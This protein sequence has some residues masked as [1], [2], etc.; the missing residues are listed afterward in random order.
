MLHQKRHLFR[1][2]ALE[3]LASPER[4]DELMLV[5][6]PRSWLPVLTLGSLVGITFFWLIYGRIP[7]I[8]EGQGVLIYPHQV[9]SLQSKSS[10]QLLTVN[11]KVGDTI[12]KGQ[13]LATINQSEL[14][15]QL[16]Q[17]RLKLTELQTQ[18]RSIS[19]LQ[20][21]TI[22]QNQQTK[23][24]QYTYLQQRI[25]ELQIQIPLLKTRENNSTK[26]QRQ[27]LEQKLKALQNLI[28]I[29]QERIDNRKYLFKEGA[30]SG[31]IPYEAELKYQ[32][33]LAQISDLKAQLKELDFKE[34]ENEKDYREKI[35][36][37]ADYQAQLK[38]L[39]SQAAIQA[40]QMLESATT[41]KKEIQDVQR[42]IARLELQ[43][44]DNSQILSPY[45]GHILELTVV[46]GQVVNPGT[47]LGVIQ[48]ENSSSKLIAVT[49]FSV[50]DGKKIQPGMTV[51][52]TPQIV[53]REQFGG[54]LGKV[55][56][57]SP[58][59]ITKEAAANEVGNLEIVQG[60]T[61]NQSEGLIQV[62]A[63]LTTSSTYF[64]GYKWSSSKGPQ[65][66][67]SSG[68]TTTVRIKLEN[69][70]PITF[71]FPILRQ[72]SGIY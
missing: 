12:K 40:E 65:L 62:S 46:P 50:A 28:P 48:S 68:T 31:E 17:Q 33:N 10:G 43:L 64:S 53:K 42:E 30:V 3:R 58:F 9:I 2:V 20:E 36:T 26:Q 19:S 14:Q 15:K 7:I 4:L 41:R 70:A 61:S 72:Y 47:H 45:S 23:K 34:A 1:Q 55:S 67:I 6:T 22:A 21:I 11:I 27:S 35:T 38:Q 37:I 44:K 57:V 49:Y 51:Q 60:L 71:I 32:E 54:I 16:Q 24:Q 52:I 63:N 5:V 18:D 29:L 39:E 66:K 59:P 69:R 13:V 25:Q 56:T 8:V